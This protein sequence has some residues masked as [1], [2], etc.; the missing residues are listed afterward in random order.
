MEDLALHHFL[1]GLHPRISNIVRCR[2]PKNLNE[3][4]NLAI[5]EERIQQTLYK[6]PQGDQK[7]NNHNN[8]NRPRSIKPQN[9]PY[10][11]QFRGARFSGPP[12]NSQPICRYCK[13]PGHDI[14]QCKRREFN[15]NRFRA[16]HHPTPRVTYVAQSDPVG[17]DEID[18]SYGHDDS[19]P[20]PL[21]E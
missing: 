17:Q 7:P 8:D 4:V 9:G 11:N 16:Q 10:P 2:S 5:S 14:S 19:S 15:N 6:R 3:A 12:Q 13:L 20:D 18:A 21:N 1:M